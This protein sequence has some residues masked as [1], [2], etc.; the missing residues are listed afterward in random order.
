V[1]AAHAAGAGRRT[2]P[3][4]VCPSSAGHAD[5]ARRRPAS[6]GNTI[7]R[8]PIRRAERADVL[9]G[10]AA[11]ADQRAGARID[12]AP[13]RY[14]LDRARHAGVRHLDEAR[15]DLVGRAAKPGGL[16]LARQ[17]GQPALHRRALEREREAV[18]LEAPQEQV[19]VGERELVRG[20]AAASHR[21][22]PSGPGSMAPPNQQPALSKGTSRRPRRHCARSIGAQPR[23]PAGSKPRSSSSPS[24]PAT[25]RSRCR[26]CSPASRRARRRPGG[27]SGEAV[28]SACGNARGV[29]EPAE[30]A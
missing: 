13:H 27:R 20:S 26:P 6:G 5:P 29:G 10:C 16:E 8:I 18:G 2:G 1:N 12:A 22:K 3:R 7:R 14:L 17:L 28:P 24:R 30:T 19:G 11:E 23:P 25:R 21:A 9:P 4:H 15:G